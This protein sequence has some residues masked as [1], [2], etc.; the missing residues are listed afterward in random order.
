MLHSA[1]KSGL[2]RNCSMSFYN[3]FSMDGILFCC[4]TAEPFVQVKHPLGTF[5]LRR[6]LAA[7]A[8]FFPTL[9]PNI[10]LVHLLT[11][12]LPPRFCTKQLCLLKEVHVHYGSSEVC[13]SYLSYTRFLFLEA[14]R[15]ASITMIGT[16]FDVVSTSLH[17]VFQFFMPG[18]GF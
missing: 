3:M 11:I 15:C 12:A 1:L 18:H 10:M 13:R 8:A 5:P 7:R 9:Q 2:D 14:K 17:T 6:R 4:Q 16:E